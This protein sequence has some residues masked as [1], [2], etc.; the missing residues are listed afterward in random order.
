MN[1]KRTASNRKE[2]TEPKAVP[3]PAETIMAKYAAVIDALDEQLKTIREDILYDWS[4]QLNRKVRILKVE[5][6]GNAVRFFLQT[7][8]KDGASAPYYYES[9]MT[10]LSNGNP[11]SLA[12]NANEAA[13][14]FDSKSPPARPEINRGA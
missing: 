12:E 3:H 10:L 6:K 13:A 8:D 2:E 7:F 11:Q 5:R 1:N 4:N 14:R 9:Q